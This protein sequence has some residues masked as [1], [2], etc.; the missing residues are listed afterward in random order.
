[1]GV[2]KPPQASPNLPEA[3]PSIPQA[4][5]KHSQAFP[6]PPQASQASPEMPS[7][8]RTSLPCVW[9]EAPHKQ[10]YD[11]GG[12]QRFKLPQAYPSLPEAFPTIP[13]ATPSLPEVCACVCVCVGVC[14]CVCVCVCVLPYLGLS[15]PLWASDSQPARLKPLFKPYYI[16][17]F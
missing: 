13:Q 3:F 8:D 17:L 6:K 14:V 11:Q 1:M 4:S 10:T 12:P 15:G 2:A 7:V 16:K 5:P 9:L